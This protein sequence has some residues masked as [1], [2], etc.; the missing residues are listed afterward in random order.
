MQWILM[1]VLLGHPSYKVRERANSYLKGKIEAI[2]ALLAGEKSTD[3][4]IAWRSKK[5]VDDWYESRVLPTQLPWF[6]N[7]NLQYVLVVDDHG[8]DWSK[9]RDAT[10][11]ACVEKL[12]RRENIDQFL[13]ALRIKEFFWRL[14]NMHT[15][16]LWRFR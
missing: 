1:V 6:A 4:E 7:H 13:R 2:P 9:W 16:I 10:R 8:P 5:L 12:R 14:E 15:T 11:Q 3:E